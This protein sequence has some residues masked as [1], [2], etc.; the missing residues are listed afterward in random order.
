[1]IKVVQ[2]LPG[3]EGGREENVGEGAEGRNDP[4]N[5]CTCEL[6]KKKKHT[7]VV[8]LNSDLLWWL[9]YSK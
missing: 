7:T 3:T 2:H 1:V 8:K 4:N 9:A 6:K 5:V